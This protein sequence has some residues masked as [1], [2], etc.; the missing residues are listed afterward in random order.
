MSGRGDGETEF[1]SEAR[2]CE[3]PIE[4]AIY[5][6]GVRSIRDTTYS[7][8]PVWRSA[9][10]CPQ[11]FFNAEIAYFFPPVWR[12]GTERMRWL[13]RAES[14]SCFRAQKSIL[15]PAVCHSVSLSVLCKHSYGRNFDSILIRFCTVIR[16]PKSKIEFVW[17]KKNLITPSP[18]LP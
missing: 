6:G 16:G 1:P 14:S 9:G 17:D 5:R 13:R 18:I 2:R 8:S 4:A 10:L 15:R 11:N 12:T 3:A 7:P